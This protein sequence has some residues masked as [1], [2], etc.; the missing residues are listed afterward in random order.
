MSRYGKRFDQ[1]ALDLIL[2]KGH[3]KIAY[4]SAK[5][6]CDPGNE[7]VAAEEA[8]RPDRPDHFTGPVRIRY[9]ERRKRLLDADNGW[10][11]YHTD[12][13]VDSKI[14]VDDTTEFIPERPVHVQEK[15]GEESLTIEIELISMG[16]DKP[17]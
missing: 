3:V 8:P 10:T 4:G 15:N 13:L 7:Q 12:A 6:E 11:K 1:D 17:A 2:A 16:V 9:H 5:C 14:L